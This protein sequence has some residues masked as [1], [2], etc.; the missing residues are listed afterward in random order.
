MNR[1]LTP[2]E[3]RLDKLWREHFGQPM[4]M[5]GAPDVARRILRQN[6]VHV[7]RPSDARSD[8]KGG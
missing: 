8:P 4:P 3:V 5:I 6:G 2:E 1:D 7:R